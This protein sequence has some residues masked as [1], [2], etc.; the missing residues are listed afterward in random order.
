MDIKKVVAAITSVA[1][2]TVGASMAVASGGEAVFKKKC[3]ACHN[4]TDKKKVGPGLAGVFGRETPTNGKL[5]E[6]GLTAWL[7]DPKAVNPK[8]RM[9]N[10]KLS[11]ADIGA[12]VDYLKTL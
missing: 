9:P 6:H 3:K 2:L 1:V 11:D 4:I 8:S 10:L 7:K 12:L 5:D